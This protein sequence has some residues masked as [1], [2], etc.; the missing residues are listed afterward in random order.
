[1]PPDKVR[2]VGEPVAIVVAESIY[3]AEDAAELLEIAYAP[4]PAVVR[5]VDAVKLGAPRLWDEAS[6]NICIDIEGGDATA[7]G[8]LFGA[9]PTSF[10]SILGCNASPAS[11]W[12]RAPQPP[13]TIRPQG[14]T[15]FT[16]AAAAALPS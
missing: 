1:M 5:T 4:L 9:P 16:L 15:R 12:S 10:S 7:T 3:Q 14:I 8:T 6:D 2:L 13:N 11:Q